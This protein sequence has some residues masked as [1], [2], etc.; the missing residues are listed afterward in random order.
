MG[1][2]VEG[3]AEGEEDARRKLP[4]PLVPPLEGELPRCWCWWGERGRCLSLLTELWRCNIMCVGEWRGE[5]AAEEGKEPG[6]L[7]LSL[8]EKED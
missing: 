3:E 8:S 1:A 6:L 5:V 4:L 2:E 7:L